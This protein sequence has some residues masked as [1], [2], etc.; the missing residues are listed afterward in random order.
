LV[1]VARRIVACSVIPS[2]L[3]LMPS[4]IMSA[5]NL[6]EDT[7]VSKWPVVALVP[8]V[9]CAGGASQGAT[10]V[11]VSGADPSLVMTP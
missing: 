9:S 1:P 5:G 10:G 8:G 7:P 2:G 4:S 11:G 6:A 3:P